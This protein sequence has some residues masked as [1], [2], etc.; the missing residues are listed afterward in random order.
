[1]ARTINYRGNL[2][3]MRVVGTEDGRHTISVM[4]AHDGR[5]YTAVLSAPNL[6][7]ASEDELKKIVDGLIDG[8]NG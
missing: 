3:T 2:W 6:E 7:S 4:R 8:S 5:E 1:M